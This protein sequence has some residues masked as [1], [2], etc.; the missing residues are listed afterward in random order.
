MHARSV[1]RD[2]SSARRCGIDGRPV[3][4]LYPKIVVRKP[5]YNVLVVRAIRDSIGPVEKLREI[6]LGIT[7]IAQRCV[8]IVARNSRLILRLKISRLRNDCWRFLWGEQWT[9]NSP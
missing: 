7:R 2:E 5:Y 4:Q 9:K 3:S 6:F 1:V 8:N